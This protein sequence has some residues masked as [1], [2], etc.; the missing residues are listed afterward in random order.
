VDG[1]RDTDVESRTMVYLSYRPLAADRLTVER[2]T[3]DPRNQHGPLEICRRIG[4]E[5]AS[6]ALNHDARRVTRASVCDVHDAA[7]AHA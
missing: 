2:P 6:D 5:R 3:S 7:E 4:Y 1:A